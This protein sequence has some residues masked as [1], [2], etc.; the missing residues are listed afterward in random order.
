MAT[1]YLWVEN[2]KPRRKTPSR[3]AVGGAPPPLRKHATFIYSCMFYEE[4]KGRQFQ[5]TVIIFGKYFVSIGFGLSR[6]F[7][8]RIAR[9]RNV[10]ED[11]C[12]RGIARKKVILASPLG[13]ET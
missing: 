5:R 3:R 8:R 11:I 13:Y 7:Y 9:K 4:T 1:A 2:S 12:F 10:F 6:C